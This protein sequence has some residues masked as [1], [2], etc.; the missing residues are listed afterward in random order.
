MAIK[1]NVVLRSGILITNAYIV[2]DV[3]K[4]KVQFN[5]CKINVFIY[6]N[7][8]Y[9][10]AN[11]NA[12]NGSLLVRQDDADYATYFDE[13]ILK[14]QGKTDSQQGYEYVKFRDGELNEVLGFSI[15]WTNTEDC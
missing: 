9:R 10:D 1:A 2:I 6:V 5:G 3:L 11:I 4:S 15:N 7:E 12:A 8:S 14:T 13:T